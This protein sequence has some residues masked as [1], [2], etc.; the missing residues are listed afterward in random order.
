MKRQ[1]RFLSKYTIFYC[2]TKI[3]NI[4]QTHI[5]KFKESVLKGLTKTDPQFHKKF[6][7]FLSLLF[8]SRA[9]LMEHLF[10]ICLEDSLSRLNY[11]SNDKKSGSCRSCLSSIICSGL[12]PCSRNTS[13]FCMRN[14]SLPTT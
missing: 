2:S 11:K 1:Q 7:H 8:H 6:A 14:S 4:L 12:I 9:P 5:V 13:M 10:S 3:K